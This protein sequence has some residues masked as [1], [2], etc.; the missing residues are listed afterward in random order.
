MRC[1]AFL[2]NTSNKN[3]TGH[4]QINLPKKM[5]DAMGWDIDEHLQIDTIKVG[6]ERGIYITRESDE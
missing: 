1:K 3:A 6:I 5:W 2:R 4:Y